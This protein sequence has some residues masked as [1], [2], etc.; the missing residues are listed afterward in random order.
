[1]VYH[2]SWNGFETETLLG[3][4]LYQFKQTTKGSRLGPALPLDVTQLDA[5]GNMVDDILDE[6]IHYFKPNMYFKTFK[7][8]GNGDRLILYLTCFVHKL[9]QKIVGLN[10]KQCQVVL[11]TLNQEFVTLPNEASFPF[12]TFYPPTNDQQEVEKF[13]AYTQQLKSELGHRVVERVFQYPEEDGTGSKFW[14]VFA[15]APFLEDRKKKK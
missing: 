7:I 10:K 12:A 15:K 4:G 8:K 2:S 11:I 9:L 1:M 13:L 3:C 5:D 6:V 14:T